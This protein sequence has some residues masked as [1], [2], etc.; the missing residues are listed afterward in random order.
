MNVNEEPASF[1]FIRVHNGYS[2][3]HGF[4]PDGA[5]AGLAAFFLS[6]GF[7]GAPRFLPTFISLP[8]VFTVAPVAAVTPADCAPLIVVVS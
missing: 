2:L 1:A 7:A 3:D 8:V 5:G 4:G 6:P